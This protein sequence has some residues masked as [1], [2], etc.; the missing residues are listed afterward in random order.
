MAEEQPTGTVPETRGRAPAT[1]P[2]AARPASEREETKEKEKGKRGRTVSMAFNP[3]AARTCC[4]PRRPPPS[5]LR[6]RPA[7]PRPCPLSNPSFLPI[8][9]FI[10]FWIDCIVY[11]AFFITSLTGV[12]I[13][14]SGCNSAAAARGYSTDFCEVR[15]R[16]ATPLR[17]AQAAASA[18]CTGC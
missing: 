2:E 15:Y 11:L 12:G 1:D 9:G 13:A 16:C 14:Q 7:F 3:G 8:S 10:L 5:T 4:G 17:S 18:P 6:A